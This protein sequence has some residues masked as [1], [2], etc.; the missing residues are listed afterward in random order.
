METSMSMLDDSI[1][2]DLYRNGN[3]EA[4]GV[5]VERYSHYVFKV[6][7]SILQDIPLSE[8]AVQDTFIKAM[9]GLQSG[10]YQ[11]NGTVKSWLVQ[12]AH[13]ICIDY[14]RKLKRIPID[15]SIS[16]TEPFSQTIA[17][18]SF[19]TSRPL[20]PE[21]ILINKEEGDNLEI[22]SEEMFSLV[23]ELPDV[24]KEV[25]MLRFFHDFSFQEVAEYQDVSINTALGRM[26]YA[27]INLRK[28]IEETEG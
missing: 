7:Y 20:N 15:F 12:I 22:S 24:Q 11:E 3:L 10:N 19:T 1:L 23:S 26:R 27:L 6:A 21:E 5:V 9:I 18:S 13:N 4:F 17:S 28:K 16:S 25:I 14:T 2:V 8:D